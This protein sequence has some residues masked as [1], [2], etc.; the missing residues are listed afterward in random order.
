LFGPSRACERLQRM[1]R[2]APRMRIQRVQRRRPGDVPDPGPDRQVLRNAGDRLVRNAEQ[3]EAAAGPDGD[4]SLA[5]PGG[6]GRA[7]AAGADDS[8]GLEHSLSSSSAMDTG[9]KKGTPALVPWRASW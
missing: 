3:N 9:P 1:K 7:D 8:D 5:Q 6:D 4:S 2:E